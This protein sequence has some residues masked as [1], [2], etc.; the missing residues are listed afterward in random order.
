MAISITI[1]LNTKRGPGSLE[2]NNLLIEDN[3]HVNDLNN[4]ID[5]CS[6]KLL[7]THTYPSLIW[8]LLKIEIKSFTITFLKRKAKQ[9]SYNLRKLEQELII[10]QPIA[11]KCTNV[12][13]KINYLTKVVEHFMYTKPKEQ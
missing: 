8:E 6:V 11:D 3:D 9:R 12:A 7:N 4:F 2:F 13:D 10:A 1:I 5:V